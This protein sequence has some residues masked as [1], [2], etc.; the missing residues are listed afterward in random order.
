MC[1]WYYQAVLLILLLLNDTH[2]KSDCILLAIFRE[3]LNKSYFKLLAYAPTLPRLLVL[4]K[5]L[6]FCLKYSKYYRNP[7]ALL[8]PCGV[9][10]A[11]AMPAL[12]WP[13][14]MALARWRAC[15][16]RQSRIV[17]YRYFHSCIDVS[18]CT[19]NI[20]MHQYIDVSFHPYSQ[21]SACMRSA[22][23]QPL[24][25]FSPPLRYW[26]YSERP[27]GPFRPLSPHAIFARCPG[28][29]AS[30]TCCHLAWWWAALCTRVDLWAGPHLWH[31]YGKCW[32]SKLGWW[33][34]S[35]LLIYFTCC[36]VTQQSCFLMVGAGGGGQENDW[37]NE[38]TR[39]AIEWV[40]LSASCTSPQQL[41]RGQASSP[42]TPWPCGLLVL[43]PFP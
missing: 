13:L 34:I 25:P 3:M 2:H 16:S 19:Q 31:V 39:P 28:Y 41:G 26:T 35:G 40:G 23:W 27:L 29:A 21:R 18:Y 15:P 37:P 4:H 5:T 11:R 32:I 33:S 42:A 14:C 24:S 12:H 30:C 7:R 6:V 9:Y 17:L 10:A 1:I 43:G 22:H 36:S 20:A 38:D 8:S